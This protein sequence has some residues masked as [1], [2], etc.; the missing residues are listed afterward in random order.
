[1]IV[2]LVHVVAGISVLLPFLYCNPLRCMLLMSSFLFLFIAALPTV[3]GISHATCLLVTRQLIGCIPSAS[4]TLTID[5]TNFYGPNPG[6]I[7]VNIGCTGALTINGAFTRI[8]CSMAAGIAGV[9]TSDVI[10][11]TNGGTTSANTDFTIHYG[12]TLCCYLS[13]GCSL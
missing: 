11:T 6:T 1:M 2:S 7:S 5:G 13:I 3:T 10:V 9:T 8:T 4:G 12:K